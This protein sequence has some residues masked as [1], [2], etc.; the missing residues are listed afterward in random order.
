MKK[1]IFAIL[2]FVFLTPILRADIEIGQG[3]KTVAAAGTRE[4]LVSTSTM[5]TK[6][7]I[8]ALEGNTSEVVVGGSGVIASESTRAGVPIYVTSGLPDC[9][10]IESKFGTVGNLANIYLDVKTNADGVSFTYQNERR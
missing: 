1:F 10:T 8:C 7:D 5:Y 4:A 9:Y 6:V 2:A 3:R